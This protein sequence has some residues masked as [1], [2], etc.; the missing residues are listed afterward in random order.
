MPYAT[1]CVKSCWPLLMPSTERPIILVVDDTPENIDVIKGVL[2][3]DYQIR[4]A[5]S[6]ELALRLARVAPQPELI[7]LDIMMPDM[8]GYEVLRRLKADPQTADIPVIFV[9]A[10]VHIRDEVQGLDLGAV[11]YIGKPFSPPIVRARVKTHLALTRARRQLAEQNQRLMQE[12]RLLEDVLTRLRETDRFD[13]S[14]LRFQLSSVDR[15]NGDVLMAATTPDGRQLVLV[16]DIA[17]HGPPAAA[18]VPLISHVFYS[19]VAAGE[20]TEVLL[21]QLNQV[22]Y[23]RLPL[24]IFMAFSL[25]EVAAGRTRLRVWNGGLPGCF[26]YRREGGVEPVTS[27]FF[28]LGLRPAQDFRQDLAALA[29]APGDRFFLFSDGLSECENPQGQA[30]GEEA[31]IALLTVPGDAPDLQAV[32]QA[33]ACHLGSED[34]RDDLTLVE[35]QP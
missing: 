12:R 33:A 21:E 28:P 22:M 15:S 1:K 10:L 31:V 23:E 30:F 19:L 8:D 7:L 3:N 6:G 35:I 20:A 26:C 18:S 5:I 24:Q 34:F 4:P 17:G 29:W 32:W 9:T 13:P 11:D 25:V 2:R 27:E 14:H 16:G